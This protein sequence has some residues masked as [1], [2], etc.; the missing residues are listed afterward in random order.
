MDAREQLFNETQRKRIE[1]R[2]IWERISE[3]ELSPLP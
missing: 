1:R 2:D 3:M